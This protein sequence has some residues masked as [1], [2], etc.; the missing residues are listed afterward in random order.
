MVV[1]VLSYFLSKWWKSKKKYID[2]CQLAQKY[3]QAGFEIMSWTF[4]GMR[5]VRQVTWAVNIV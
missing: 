2:L 5:G 4:N 1:Y 3:K